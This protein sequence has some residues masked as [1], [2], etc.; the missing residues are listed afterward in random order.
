M[1]PVSVGLARTESG[2][3]VWAVNGTLTAKEVE[4]DLRAWTFSGEQVAGERRN[5]TLPPNQATELGG[6]T[7]KARGPVVVSARLLDPEGTVIARA[8][9]WPEPFKYF[10]F[11][12]PEIE[13]KKL[14]G[15]QLRLRVKRP[16]KGVLLSA[17]H[18]VTWS[19]NMLDLMP[20]DEQIILASGLGGAEAQVKWLA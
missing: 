2:A 12:D 18:D 5:A 4:L 9:L 16:A 19:D 20:E 7:V 15:D 10:K 17:K 1:A 3:E 14:P 11:P 13:V 8:A 6:F